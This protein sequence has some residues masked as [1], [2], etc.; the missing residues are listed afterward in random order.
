MN[1]TITVRKAEIAELLTAAFPEYRGRKFKVEMTD[2]L[3]VDRIG[4][5]GSADE[6]IA[7]THDGARWLAQVPVL[8]KMSA[9]CGYLSTRPEVILV[10]HTWF[11]GKDMGVTFHVHPASPF[12]PKMIAEEAI[13]EGSKTATF[14][15]VV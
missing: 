12:L 7:L 10:V 14:L 13:P 5:G 15:P 2:R 3:W 8:S 1:T 4:G 11:C 9:P 6:I